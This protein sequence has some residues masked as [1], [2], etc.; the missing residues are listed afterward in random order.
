[1]TVNGFEPGES[2]GGPAECDGKYHGDKDLLVA[3]SS[4]WYSGGRRCQRAIR[5]TSARTGRSVEARVVDECK[6]PARLMQD[7][8]GL[9][10]SVGEVPVTWSDA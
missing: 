10:T 4:G 5:I 8:L 2:G 7:A 3:L 6:F 1:M 9:D